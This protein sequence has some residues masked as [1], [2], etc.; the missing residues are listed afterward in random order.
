MARYAERNGRATRCM[1][2]LL[3]PSGAR[4]GCVQLIKRCVLAS[5]AD[6][7]RLS[8]LF[9]APELRA[10]RYHVAHGVVRTIHDLPS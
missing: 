5:V 7:V 2:T 3:T 1:S 8:A 6:L 4:S 9:A 10:L